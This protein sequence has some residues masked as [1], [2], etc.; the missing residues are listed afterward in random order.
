MGARTSRDILADPITKSAVNGRI[1]QIRI[2]FERILDPWIHSF[3]IH[4]MV[5]PVS[6]Y[7]TAKSIRRRKGFRPS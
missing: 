2:R 4:S 6:R 7:N 5:T 1:A 3:A